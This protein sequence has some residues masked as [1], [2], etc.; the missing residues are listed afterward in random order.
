MLVGVWLWWGWDVIAWCW[1]VCGF[2]VGVLL[3]DLWYVVSGGL[4]LDCLLICV[5][6]CLRG[7]DLVVVLRILC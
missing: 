6:A 2:G 1:F 3:L 4:L 7:F 5:V